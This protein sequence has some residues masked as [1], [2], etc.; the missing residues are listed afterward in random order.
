MEARP[1]ISPN[2]VAQPN[3]VEQTLEQAAQARADAG[4]PWMPVNND[5]A[6]WKFAKANNLQDQ[7]TD[8]LPF[9]YKGEN[10]LVQVFNLGIVY[11]KV[12]DFG[13]ISII[14]K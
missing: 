12:G 8:E 4:K 11:C 10:Y 2:E 5:G 6:L 3:P 14:R 9:T 13:K 1:D 7:Q